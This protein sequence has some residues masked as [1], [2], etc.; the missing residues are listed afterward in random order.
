MVKSMTG[1]GRGEYSDG[2]RNVVI[3]IKSVN[4][5]Y[6]E[7]SF[8]LSRRYAF[9]EEPLKALVKR[10]MLRGKVEVGV[11]VDY[12]TE[13]DT[14][15]RLNI[16]AAKQYYSALSELKDC[17]GLQGDI[18]LK[19]IAD[20]P[21]VMKQIPDIDNEDEVVK[22]FERALMQAIDRFDAM[23]RIEGQRISEDILNRGGIIKQHLEEIE[24]YGPDIVASYYEKIKERIKDLLAQEAELPEDR[25]ALEAAIFADR[26]NVTEEIVRLKSHLLQLESIVAAKD[27]P[28]GKKLDFLVQELNRE[29]NT[30]GSK[31]NDLRITNNVLEMKSEI[32]K[33]REQV[34]NIE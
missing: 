10:S 13:D 29:V 11:F 30:I 4:H 28:N 33:I 12:L 5:R 24:K 25:I 14:M 20:M 27:G 18:D 17:F 32:E 21:D 1:F 8:R 26:I 3:E 34:Q 22:T 7:I 16:P 31:A 15:V 19:L 2:K 9:A 6:C 23:R